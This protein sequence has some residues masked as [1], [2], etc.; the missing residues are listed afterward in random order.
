M[1]SETPE[2]AVP[3]IPQLRTILLP[4]D[5]KRVRELCS[6]LRRGDRAGCQ[7]ESNLHLCTRAKCPGRWIHGVGVHPCDCRH[8]RTSVNYLRPQELHGLEVEEVITHGDV[9]AEI[10]RVATEREVDLIVI[11]SHGRTV[12][13]A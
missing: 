6:G 13:A 11:S 10:V 12:S 4:T 5:F 2:T 3:P 7:S 9:S 1:K 8:Q